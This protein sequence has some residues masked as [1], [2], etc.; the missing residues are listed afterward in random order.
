VQA[1]KT[2]AEAFQFKNGYF[3]VHTDAAHSTL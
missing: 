2:F 1:A 3:A